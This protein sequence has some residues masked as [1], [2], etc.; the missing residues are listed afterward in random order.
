MNAALQGNYGAAASTSNASQGGYYGQMQPS[1]PLP[2]QQYNRPNQPMSSQFPMNAGGA[3][4]SYLQP[5]PQAYAPVMYPPSYPNQPYLQMN[6]SP[7]MPPF[8]GNQQQQQLVPPPASTYPY[9]SQPFSSVTPSSIPYGN[10]PPMTQ[11]QQ[12]GMNPNPQQPNSIP[13]ASF[14]G[15]YGNPPRPY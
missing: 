3:Y 5:Q 7:Y 6:Y 2:P 11:Q 8:Y 10:Y 14:P 15:Y 12:P 1:F 13:G 9:Q 4:P